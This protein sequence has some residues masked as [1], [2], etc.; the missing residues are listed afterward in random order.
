[1]PHAAALRTS[2]IATVAAATLLGAVPSAHA[3]THRP[4][5]SDAYTI[6]PNEK[7][8]FPLYT[9]PE[10]GQ[11]QPMNWDGY[12][13]G[14]APGNNES[15]HW[16]DNQYTEVMFTGCSWEG[17][18]VT[19]IMLKLW[20]EIPYSFDADLGVNTLTWC[21]KGANNTSIGTW[22]V[23]VAGGTSRYFTIPALNGSIYTQS[24][25]SV[26]TV[27]VDTSAAD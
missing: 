25:V 27:Y 15:R 10:P 13:S 24:R 4:V 23:N 2:L 18:P 6:K 11:I 14:W 19:S 20:Q 5:D 3:D 8:L 21:L 7:G 9:T 12:L 1:M 26:R 16:E 17:E 22:N